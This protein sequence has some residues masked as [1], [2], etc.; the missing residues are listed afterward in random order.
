MKGM[1][2]SCVLLS[3]L[4]RFT[5]STIL[6]SH[7]HIYINLKKSETYRKKDQKKNRD[8]IANS[9]NLGGVVIGVFPLHLIYFPD[10]IW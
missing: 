6:F 7:A 4:N 9:D 2:N 5:L 1:G 3:V 10:F 8:K